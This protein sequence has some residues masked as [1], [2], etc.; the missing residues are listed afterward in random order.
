MNLDPECGLPAGFQS[1]AGIIV[2]NDCDGPLERATGELDC[3]EISMFPALRVSGLVRDWGVLIGKC[4]LRSQKLPC[5]TRGKG[6]LGFL[7]TLHGLEH[8][9]K[10]GDYVRSI[11]GTRHCGRGTH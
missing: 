11:P 10:F 7:A 9:Q 1:L 5:G 8:T 4:W 6:F 2:D 3:S